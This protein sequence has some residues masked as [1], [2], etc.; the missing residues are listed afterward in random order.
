M[1]ELIEINPVGREK[2]LQIK[3]C[4]MLILIYSNPIFL[5]KYPFVFSKMG[6]EHMKL[7]LTGENPLNI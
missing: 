5:P 6:E 4:L 3:F 1:V 2:I 7:Q